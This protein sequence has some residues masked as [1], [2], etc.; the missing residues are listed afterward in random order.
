MN[1]YVIVTDSSCDLPADLVKQYG[2]E[3]V[4]LAVT[5][6]GGETTLNSDLDIKEFYAQLR[7][8]KRATTSAANPDAFFSVFDK[9]LAAGID[10]LYLGF[11][12]GLSGTCNAGFIAARELSEKYPERKCVVL[13]TLC[14]SLGQGLIVVLAA[15]KKLQGATLDEVYEYAKDLKPNLVH[16][17]TVDDLFF[18][19]RGGRVSAVTAVAGSALGIKPVL[20]VD[21]AGHLI[22]IGIKKGRKGSLND[23]CE[24]MK[25]SAIDPANQLV[26]ISHGDCEE[27]AKYLA[28][29]ITTEMG[30]KE[31]ILISHVGPVI[32]AHAG[33]GT[34]ALFFIG[35]ER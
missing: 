15:K 29:K 9:Y 33:P 30:V 23:L 14:A 16:L 1:P 19:K 12:S 7:D 26:F 6:E 32:G 25:E 35:K 5:V 24:R 27:D 2:L 13:D 34:V 28:D 21:D 4:Q 8:K 20:H 17:F 22:K 11:S 18:L 3:I 10:V 31:P